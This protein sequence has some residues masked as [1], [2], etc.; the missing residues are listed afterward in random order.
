[1]S[2]VAARNA[3]MEGFC[4]LPF[5]FIHSCLP[6]IVVTPLTCQRACR[7]GAGAMLSAVS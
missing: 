5:F 7:A 3:S 2:V 4:S 6:V 1:M